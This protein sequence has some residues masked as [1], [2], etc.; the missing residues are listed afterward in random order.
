MAYAVP[1]PTTIVRYGRSLRTLAEFPRLTVP[2]GSIPREIA[3]K[4][5]PFL[6]DPSVES[7]DWISE[8]KLETV[9][10]MVQES[11]AE[12]HRRT[13]ILVVFDSQYPRYAFFLS[14]IVR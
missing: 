3:K 5:Q 8:L 14:V 2:R 9:A 7:S 4:Y 12:D 1:L 11:M 13:K 6:L 10:T